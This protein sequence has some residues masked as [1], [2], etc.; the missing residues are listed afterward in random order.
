ML[1]FFKRSLSM[2]MAV[3]FLFAL[4]PFSAITAFAYETENGYIYTD[5]YG[6]AFL[7][8]VEE[9]VTGDVVIPS[10]LGGMEVSAIGASVFYDRTDITSVTI[11]NTV[12]R[13]CDHAFSGCTSLAEVTIPDSVKELDRFAFGSCTS[14]VR[15]NIGQGL[16]IFD[17]YG[18]F[19]AF[20]GCSALEE[21]HVSVENKTFASE[22]GVLFSKDKKTLIDY[23]E[24]KKDA[25]YTIPSG[26]SVIREQ[27]FADANRLNTVSISADVK[28]IG[29][30]AFARANLTSVVFSEGVE[31]IG[32]SAFAEC[33]SLTQIHFPD[34][35][36]SIGDYAL[37]DCSSLETV[38]FG[39]GLKTIGEG[40]FYSYKSLSLVEINVASENAHFSSV[41]GVLFSKDGKTLYVYPVA[42]EET[43]YTVPAGTERLEQYAFHNAK[44]LQSVVLPEGLKSIGGYAFEFTDLDFPTIPSTLEEVGNYAF[45][46]RSTWFESFDDGV[47]YLG[48]VAYKYK[49]QMP[50]DCEIVLEE[51]TASVAPYAFY[52]AN[53][54]VS[55]TL[56]ASV[57]QIG[58]GAFGDIPSLREV[59]GGTGL[60]EIGAEAFWCCTS[61]SAFPFSD[62][63]EQIGEGA[64][65]SCRALSEITIPSK[66][67]VLEYEV[68]SFCTGLEEIVIPDNVKVIRDYAFYNCDGIRSITVGSGL[69]EVEAFTAFGW[70]SPTSITLGTVKEEIEPIWHCGYNSCETLT[71]SEG[72]TEIGEMAFS[73][74]D[75]LETVVLPNT[76]KVIGDAAF[77]D[78][79]GLREIRIPESVETIGRDAFFY[80]NNL[81]EIQMPETDILIGYNAFH[82]TAWYDAQPD[83]VVYL[84][85]AA[86]YHKGNDEGEGT[87]AIREGTLSISPKAMEDWTVSEYTELVLPKSLKK[88]GDGAFCGLKQLW[89]ITVDPENEAFFVDETGALM[90]KDQKTLVLYPAGFNCGAYEVPESVTAIAPYAFAGNSSIMAVGLPDGLETIGASAF[91]RAAITRAEIPAGVSVIPENAF[92]NCRDLAKVTFEG[93][94]TEI[95]DSAFE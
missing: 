31:E 67:E 85:R 82:N 24:G 57:K 39:E 26:V 72:V 73:S 46:D 42:K 44:N 4:L 29:D 68:F 3:L 13:I 59:R 63:I 30:Y 90:M 45:N 20:T 6:T 77:Q 2:A 25:S 51:G 58:E 65:Y 1:D 53:S 87:L 83:G 86:Y 27:A 54:L 38:S 81:A 14:L 79:D 11:P 7:V 89:S 33:E 5:S 32:V 76:L 66:L 50:S 92:L 61:L 74:F 55:V 41:D 88:I 19:S 16:E 60:V 36:T 93:T 40:L 43:T 15:V 37:T 34:S 52:S 8:G 94:I 75:S 47:V 28:T 10:T 17:V 95:G 12:E 49:G 91:E 80:C 69:E 62:T 84:G 78:C 64:F 23:P 22:D 9:T 71:I 21:I 70:C 35:L 48:R 18:D 56:P